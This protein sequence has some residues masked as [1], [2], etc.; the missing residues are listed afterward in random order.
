M[1][2]EYPEKKHPKLKSRA[3]K[4]M[5]DAIRGY[6]WQMLIQGPK[7]LDAA[8]GGKTVVQGGRDKSALFKALMEEQ[9]D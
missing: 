6:A 2:A 4:G 8:N 7:Y 1:L 9:A 3:R 5:P